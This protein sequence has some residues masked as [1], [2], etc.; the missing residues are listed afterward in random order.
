VNP[1]ITYKNLSIHLESSRAIVNIDKPTSG[2]Y[3]KP[4]ISQYLFKLYGYTLKQI[5]CHRYFIQKQRI[6]KGKYM[7]KGIFEKLKLEMN[8]EKRKLVI[9]EM[10]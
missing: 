2:R 8:V 3:F 7:G 4:V 5:W 9:C 1:T 10:I 6:G